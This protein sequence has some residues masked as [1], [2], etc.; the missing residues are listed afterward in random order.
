MLPYDRVQRRK[1]LYGRR[2]PCD[3]LV[4]RCRVATKNVARSHSCSC[5]TR[6]RAVA[7][8]P[9]VGHLRLLCWRTRQLTTLAG[10]IARLHYYLWSRSLNTHPPTYHSRYPLAYNLS[11]AT[12]TTLHAGRTPIGIALSK[13]LCRPN[14][15]QLMQYLYHAVL[16][17]L[18]IHQPRRGDGE[19]S[20]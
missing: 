1:L 2:F 17:F 7:P 6:T 15:D 13:S 11:H 20:F 3:S 5:L 4:D 12:S 10:M 18:L 14:Q 16:E 9:G 8:R 19:L